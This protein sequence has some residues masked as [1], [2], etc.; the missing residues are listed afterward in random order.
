MS[1]TILAEPE[2]IEMYK[3]PSESKTHNLGRKTD[4]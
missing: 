3:I 1:G 4:K 2:D